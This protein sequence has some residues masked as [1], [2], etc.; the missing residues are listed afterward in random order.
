MPP[1]AQAY[2]RVAEATERE[3]L[4]LEHVAFVRHVFG[5]LV[6]ELPQGVDR[7]NLEAAGLLG[8][9]EA[10]HHYDPRRGVEFKSFA[11]HRI[12]GAM[13]DELRRNSPLP[14]RMLEIIAQV[15]QAERDLPPP[16]TAAQL[17]AASGLPLKDVEQGLDAMRLADARSLGEEII[18]ARNTASPFNLAQR[19]ELQQALADGIERLPERQRLVVTLYY[20][21]DL[22]LKEIGR[23]LNVS[24]SRVSRLLAEAERALK[25][26]M[27]DRSSP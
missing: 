20:L 16:A 3:Q 27:Q 6:A 26:W 23:V 1:L 5:R 4:I 2:R 8:L 15:R 7:E 13:L 14:Q 10:A 21:E 24:E 18:D 25:Q 17:A 12:R 19:N 11:Y 9:V 22:R